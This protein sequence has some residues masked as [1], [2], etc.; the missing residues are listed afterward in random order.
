MFAPTEW[1]QQRFDNG[2]KLLRLD[3]GPLQHKFIETNVIPSVIGSAVKENNR[4]LLQFQVG[5]P[6]SDLT[7]D[8]NLTSV[9]HW[10]P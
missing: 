1:N 10:A 6:K 2:I 7:K 4:V 8:Y 9:K 5:G 3:A